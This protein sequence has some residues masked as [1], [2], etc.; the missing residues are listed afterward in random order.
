[1]HPSKM[2]K[3]NNQRQMLNRFMVA[4]PDERVNRRYPIMV[5]NVID[6]MSTLR[7]I[8]KRKYREDLVSIQNQKFFLYFL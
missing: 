6:K 2:T 7:S 8:L 4:P 3:K 5:N 1:M